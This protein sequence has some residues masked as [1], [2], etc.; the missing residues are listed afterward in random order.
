MQERNHKEMSEVD[1]YQ[2]QSWLTDEPHQVMMIDPNYRDEQEA[3][4]I[5]DGRGPQRPE[6]RK[7]RL[8]RRL[9]FQHHDGHDHREYAINAVSRSA[10]LSS[11]ITFWRYCHCGIVLRMAEDAAFVVLVVELRAIRTFA[12]A[13]EKESLGRRQHAHWRRD[14]INPKGIP[15]TAKQRGAERQRG[16]RA[17]TG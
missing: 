3:H 4:R 9:E 1:P 7:Y 15:V 17:H 6:G 2:S 16:I 10:V 14:E 5:A 13:G 11:H 8:V 12:L